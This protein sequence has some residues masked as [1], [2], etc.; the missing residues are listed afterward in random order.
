M[1]EAHLAHSSLGHDTAGDLDFDILGFQF[2]LGGFAEFF[3]DRFGI[4]CSFKCLAKRVDAL[5][6]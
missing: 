1:H 3:T 4:G 5:G 6:P 2:F